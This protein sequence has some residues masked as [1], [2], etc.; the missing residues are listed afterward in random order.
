MFRPRVI[1]VFLLAA[2]VLAG[3]VWILNLPAGEESLARSAAT[4]TN[5]RNASP[6]LPPLEENATRFAAT[7][8]DYQPGAPR[9]RNDLGQVLPFREAPLD[10]GST[11]LL[12]NGRRGQVLTISPF[13]DRLFTVRLTG[14]WDDNGQIRVAGRLEGH[15]EEDRLFH[16]WHPD[17]ARGFIELPSENIAY[18]IVSSAEEGYVVREWLFTDAVCATPVADGRSATRGLPRLMQGAAAPAALFAPAAIEVPALR[19]KPSVSDRVIYLDFD[20]ETVSGTAW[21]GGATIV[22]PPARLN[23]TQIREVWERVSRHFDPFRV[24]V[25]TVRSDYEA[26]PLN[27]RTHVITTANDQAAPGAGGIAYRD[28]FSFSDNA[29][30]IVW[31]FIDDDAPSCADIIS[32]EVGHALALRHDGRRDPHEE[33]YE[34]HGSGET[35]WAPVMGI[36][37]YRRVVQWSRGEYA[38]ANNP[39]DDLGIITDPSRLPYDTD[40]HAVSAGNATAVE[41]DRATGFI[42]RSDDRDFFRVQLPAGSHTIFLTPAAFAPVD[43]ELEVLD[44]QGQRIG[45]FNPPERLSATATFTLPSGQDVYLRVAGVGLGNPLGTGYTDYASLGAY[46]LTGFGNQEQPPSAPIGLSTTRVSGSQIRLQWTSNPSASSYVV[47][48][49]GTSLGTVFGTEFLDTGLWP[50]TDYSYAVTAL[51]QHG[52]SPASQATD[53]TSP[54][55]DEFIMDG[56]PDFAGYLLSD[57]GMRIYAAVRGA[58]LYVAT[59]SPGDNGSGGGSDHILLLSDTLLDSATTPAPWVKRGFMA[60]PGNKPFL[61][62]ESQSTYAGWF[63]TQ[64]PTALFKSRLNS[65][66]MEGTIDL[67]AEFG[68]LPENI[69]VAAVAYRTEDNGEL[70]AQAPAGNGNNN[71]E[72]A[73]F[74]RIPVTA[75]ADT[76]LN[77]TFDTLDAARAFSVTAA[78]SDPQNRPVLRWPAVPGRTYRIQGRSSLADGSWQNLLPSPRTAGPGEW[79]M[80]YTDTNALGPAK[81]Y[82]VTQP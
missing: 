65:G 6:I 20:G 18:E 28:T 35:G 17:G 59:W 38:R 34:G 31:S 25:T 68:R 30:K 19:S 53:V 36:G 47:W 82:R 77:G 24:N 51:N 72:P 48:R 42:G 50:A 27:L 75:V 46:T 80:Q 1:A 13:P 67:V 7:A 41:G 43:L 69:Y 5:G 12:Q 58:R 40:D 79:E 4:S 33:Y 37:F 45:I 8:A 70:A 81:F 44:A 74:L 62:G 39:E 54:A 52:T 66:M 55:F 21:A 78:G 71:L 11:R 14:R 56:E 23:P 3:V 61:A 73:E 76:R 64:G 26:A 63:N 9:R 15:P 29:Y 22:A 2:L 57:P 32:H 10:P 60:I 49:D 16:S